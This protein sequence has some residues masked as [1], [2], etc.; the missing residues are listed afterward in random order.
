MK[1]LKLFLCSIFFCFGFIGMTAC[2]S[3]QDIPEN[4]TPEISSSVGGSVVEPTK[5]EQLNNNEKL[6]YDALMININTFYS[7][8][9][10]RILEITALG[11][12]INGNNIKG[13]SC[14]LKIQ[15]TTQTGQ[16]NNKW[17]RL[18]LS[19][20]EDEYGSYKK[21]DFDESSFIVD[22]I[23]LASVKV[24]EEIASAGKINKALI[25]YWQEMGLL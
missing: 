12:D 19:D 7:P 21:G 6:I 23:P 20:Y 22:G 4:S 13:T 24:P 2:D 17:I 10:V 1:T 14:H 25:E 18:T 3:K 5:Y 8:S 15:A 16:T 11:Y 9:S